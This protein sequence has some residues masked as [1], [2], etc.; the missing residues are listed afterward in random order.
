VLNFMAAAGYAAPE[1]WPGFRVHGS[2]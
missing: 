2:K 1:G